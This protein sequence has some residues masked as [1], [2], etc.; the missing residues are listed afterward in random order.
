MHFIDYQIPSGDNKYYT[1]ARVVDASGA[2]VAQVGNSYSVGT[3]RVSADG[4]VGLSGPGV[5]P[6]VLIYTRP[7][8]GSSKSPDGAAIV[9]DYAGNHW[10][11]NSPSCKVGNFDGGARQGD[12]TFP[13]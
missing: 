10:D 8:P 13:C 6:Y 2:L 7:R 4:P 1:A 11:T 12:C 9:F 3:D 5:L